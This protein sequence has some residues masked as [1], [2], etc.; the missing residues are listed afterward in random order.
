MRR[1]SNALLHKQ[2][3]QHRLGFKYRDSVRV[4]IYF[5]YYV[6]IIAAILENAA[7]TQGDT[8]QTQ[9]VKIGFKEY[10]VRAV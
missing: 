3:E 6:F 1:C 7:G 10:Q 8:W 4:G 9:K 2:R 5:A